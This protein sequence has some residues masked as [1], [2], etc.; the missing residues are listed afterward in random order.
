M[1]KLSNQSI[2]HNMFPNIEAMLLV[3]TFMFHK[4]RDSPS[5]RKETAYMHNKSVSDQR[6]LC[7]HLHK[8]IHKGITHRQ[9]TEN[10]IMSF[11]YNKILAM[12]CVIYGIT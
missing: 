6:F 3:K 5:A 2:N 11:Q 7:N 1:G 9:S 8:N 4:G 10:A 12:M